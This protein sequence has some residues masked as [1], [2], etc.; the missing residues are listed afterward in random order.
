MSRGKRSSCC[1]S[2]TVPHVAKVMSQDLSSKFSTSVVVE[3]VAMHLPYAGTPTVGLEPTTQGSGPC[4]LPTEIGGLLHAE[5]TGEQ[6]V[7]V[8]HT[9]KSSDM[10]HDWEASQVWGFAIDKVCKIVN[11]AWHVAC[12]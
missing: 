9:R 5:Q 11:F 8:E 4:A 7:D 2:N 10:F 12:C 6:Q 3:H 1:L